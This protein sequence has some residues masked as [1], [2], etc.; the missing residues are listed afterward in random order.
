MTDQAGLDEMT[1]AVLALRSQGMGVNRIAATLSIGSSRV[2]RIV[3]A[4]GLRKEKREPDQA[5]REQIIALRKTGLS[6]ARVGKAV[7]WSEAF[8]HRVL[9]EAGLSG[10]EAQRSIRAAKVDPL[11]EKIIALYDGQQLPVVK[12]AAELGIRKSRVSG[13]VQAAGVY[14]EQDVLTDAEKDRI[15]A[16]RE[17]GLSMPLIALRTRRSEAAI[18]EHLEKHGL[19]ERI[20]RPIRIE[21]D[22]AY[23]TLT[24]G[25]EAVVDA[26]DVPLVE[27]RSWSVLTTKRSN[28]SIA[29]YATSGGSTSDL[30][31]QLMHRVIMGNPVGMKIDHRDHD[32]LNNRRGNLRP[33]DDSGNAHNARRSKDTGF[34]RGVSPDK[35]GRTY[36]FTASV[37]RG[38]YPT[39]EA[40]SAARTAWLSAQH[41]AGFVT[42]EKFM[43][44]HDPDTGEVLE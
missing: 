12:V 43:P 27:S 29:R 18:R 44:D 25:F 40:A 34:P 10:W 38:G 8:V 14:R 3:E 9:K 6:A 2:A 42:T 32:G 7:D 37:R 23:V 36:A 33:V 13:I 5:T 17:D 31:H 22:I 4:A 30:G 28:G 1:T 35:N 16:L 15:L 20:R 26:A 11:T 39:P 19:N 21:G 24:Q 41:G